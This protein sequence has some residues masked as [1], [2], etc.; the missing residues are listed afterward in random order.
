[1]ARPKSVDIEFEWMAP[2]EARI[3]QGVSR[4]V[5]R[6][7]IQRWHDKYDPDKSKEFKSV[8]TQYGYLVIRIK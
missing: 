3:V 4:F 7:A 8:W 2:L 6:S 5:I 1:M